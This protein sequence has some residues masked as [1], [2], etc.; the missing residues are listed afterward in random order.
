MKKPLKKKAVKKPVKKVLKKATKKVVKK[1]P[2]KQVVADKKK[3]VPFKTTYRLNMAFNN[4][5][6]SIDTDNLHDAILSLKPF[7]VKTK[8][9]VQIFRK[10]G[11]VCDRLL[12]GLNGRK[13][14]MNKTF[15]TLFIN[16]LTFK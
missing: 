7:I 16:R 9:I 6:F 14:F 3:K 12:I 10:D 8:I 4:Q 2:V 5:V 1:V 11:T 15:L 13:L